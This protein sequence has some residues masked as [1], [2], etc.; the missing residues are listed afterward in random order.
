MHAFNLTCVIPDFKV[1][2]FK[3][4]LMVNNRE[5]ILHL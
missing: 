1:R 3:G 4:E 5:A 2:A